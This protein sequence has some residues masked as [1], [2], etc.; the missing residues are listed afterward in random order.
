MNYL[1]F[2]NNKIAKTRED[3]FRTL[4][5]WR[6]KN[7]KI[8]FTNGCF[9]I[10]HKGHIEYLAKA[11]SLG[12]KLIIGLN[13]DASVKRLKGEY[14]PVNNEN[15]RAILLAALSFVDHI[16]IFD[17]DTP[18]DLIQYVH[19]DILVKGGDYNPQ[20]IV[21]YDIVKAKGGEVVTID[22]IEGYSTTIF[23]NKIK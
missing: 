23:L 4:S 11:A 10:L 7:E 2:I 6:F 20:E 12:T 13:S 17:T 5:L 8:V 19:P 16:V 14:R 1:H 15:D 9:D 18:R 3:A 22:F 21:G